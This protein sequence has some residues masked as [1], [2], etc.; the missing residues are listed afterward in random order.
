M[1]VSQICSNMYEVSRTYVK[2]SSDPSIGRHMRKL[3][4][5]GQIVDTEI[6]HLL[7]TVVHLHMMSK[8]KLTF[9]GKEIIRKSKETTVIATAN[10]KAQS[11][12]DATVYVNDLQNY[13]QCYLC[14][15]YAKKWSTPTHGKQERLH[16]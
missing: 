16:H 1:K 6:E 9:V 7:W 14:F 15:F 10:G 2:I 5:L 3:S 11:T 13:Q 4:H 12:E 8:H